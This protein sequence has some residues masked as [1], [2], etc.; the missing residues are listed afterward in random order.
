M[1]VQTGKRHYY[2]LHEKLN[3]VEKAYMFPQNV[4]PTAL[5][6]SVEAKQ[7][8]ENGRLSLRQ[9]RILLPYTCSL[10]C[11]REVGHKKSKGEKIMP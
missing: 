5:A 2:T 6:Y 3:I 8:Y 1:Y 10:Y 9:W 11:R 4:K 7:R